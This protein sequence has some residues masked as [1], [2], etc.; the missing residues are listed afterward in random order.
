MQSI[1]CDQPNSLSQVE[2]AIPECSTG[3]ALVRIRRIG[4]CGT[5]LHAFSG[6]QPY[7]SYPRILG[8]ELG[9]EIAGV[10]TGVSNLEV[11]DPVTVI[12]YLECGECIACRAG[13][14]NCCTALKVIGV[15][16][17]G[18][19]QE[20]IAHPA[21]HLIRVK[22]LSLDE[23]ALVECMAIGAHAV[24]RAGVQAGEDVL[25][26]GA[27]P[28]GYGIM[29][30]CR[31]AGARVIALDIDNQRLE[32]SRDKGGADA[33]VLADGENT[34]QL[35]WDVTE[36]NGAAAVFEAT[37]SPQSMTQAFNFIAHGGRYVL[38]SIVDA[39]IS[40]YDPDF[41]KRETT[42]LSS[43]NATRE[44]F[45]LVLQCLAEKRLDLQP[46]ITHRCSFGRFVEN[47]ATWATPGSGI[48]KG[49]IEV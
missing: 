15:H 30:F 9:G 12:P 28:I 19:M 36:G 14:P 4:I 26:V 11:G 8:H 13:K 16:C 48:I 35:I 43:R 18:G 3:E 17:D 6:S 42:L 40:F 41:H 25:V 47:F 20:Y 37:G 32:F 21:D 24:R 22:G 39:R 5:D 31:I 44:D 10:G 33:I 1:I 49:I 38:V 45:A 27:G 23:L 46:L 7:F 29:Q 34:Q 2:R